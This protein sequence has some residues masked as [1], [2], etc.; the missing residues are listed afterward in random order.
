MLATGDTAETLSTAY[1]WLEIA[2]IQACLTYAL[3]LVTH[4]RI[5][6]LILEV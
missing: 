6:T 4:E 5:E 3:C 1:P 2:D